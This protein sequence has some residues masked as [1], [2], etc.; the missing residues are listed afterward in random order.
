MA[1]TVREK[2]K[3]SGEYWVFINHKGRR[4]SKKI[5]DKRAAL[6]VKR[7]VEARLAQGDLGMLRPECP[8]VSKYGSE[9]LKSPLR[10]WSDGTLLNYVSIFN[11]YIKPHFGGKMLNE[12]KRRYVK[13]FISELDGLSPA[14][15]RSVLSVLSGIME[16]AVDDELVES[17]PCNG[18]RKFCGKFTRKKI[19]PLTADEVQ[20]ML[21]NAADLPFVY[22]AFYFTKVRSGLRLGEMMGLRWFDINFEERHLTVRRLYYFK[23]KSYSPGKNKKAR[24]VDLTP[25][26]VEVL[27]ELQAQRKLVSI[28]GDDLVFTVTGRPLTYDW[29]RDKF[30]GITPRKVRIHDL[31][32]TYATLRIG[33]GDNILDVSKQLG[34]HSVAFTIDKYA[35]WMPGEHKS[36]VDELDTLHLSAPH[37]HPSST[38]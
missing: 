22:Y 16:S 28:K 25:A 3:N 2:K 27:R 21:E 23:T 35:H 7:E 32:H 29:L 10:E 18:T 19:N 15:K 20:I 17:N 13:R 5:G 30:R 9:W 8:T 36:Q 33:K 31:R 26:T 37:A 24:R 14:R 34:H 6:A 38:K 1:V 11:Q 12:V 4:R